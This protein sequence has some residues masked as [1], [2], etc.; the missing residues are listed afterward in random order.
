MFIQYFMFQNLI[1]ICS[2]TFNWF[3]VSKG[4]KLSCNIAKPTRMHMG[5]VYIFDKR[6]KSHLCN[7]HDGHISRS[8]MST[9]VHNLKEYQTLHQFPL[10]MLHQLNEFTIQKHTVDAKPSRRALWLIRLPMY[11]IPRILI[12]HAKE[13][14]LYRDVKKPP[15]L[16]QA[17]QTKSTQDCMT[18]RKHNQT[19]NQ[20][21]YML[22]ASC[23]QIWYFKKRSLKHPGSFLRTV[24]GYWIILK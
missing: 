13:N 11:N 5:R 22:N 10:R 1:C 16:L 7:V 21:Y 9:S 20:Y 14:I 12:Q 15:Q 19:L 2:K 3:T 18:F 17:Y 6:P 23:L 24:C 4:E 8:L